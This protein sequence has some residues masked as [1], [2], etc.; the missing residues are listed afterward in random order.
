MES[1]AVLTPVGWQC[2]ALFPGYHGYHGSWLTKDRM[3]LSV[4]VSRVTG[5]LGLDK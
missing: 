5:L 1:S 4:L 3:P 2:D